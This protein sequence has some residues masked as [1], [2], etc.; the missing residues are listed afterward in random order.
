MGT[1]VHMCAHRLREPRG[2]H[3]CHKYMHRGAHHTRITDAHRC[4][5]MGMPHAYTQCAHAE[6][7]D[8]SPVLPTH[9]QTGYCHFWASACRL[10]SEGSCY[11]DSTPQPTERPPHSSGAR[12]CSTH[13]CVVPL[14]QATPQIHSAGSDWDWGRRRGS[15]CLGGQGRGSPEKVNPRCP[16]QSADVFQVRGR[17]DWPSGVQ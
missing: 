12:S 16:P 6:R 11:E 15:D 1:H 10:Q 4:V 13:S 7:Q 9:P 5:P 14:G 8:L 2:T 17:G 3:V